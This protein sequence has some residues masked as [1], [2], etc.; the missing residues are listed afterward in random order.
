MPRAWARPPQDHRIAL[1]SVW[2]R[3]RD[4]QLF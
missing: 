1:M 2:L 4:A 3:Q